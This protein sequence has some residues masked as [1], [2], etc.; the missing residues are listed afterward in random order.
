M[1]DPALEHTGAPWFL[2]NE[3]HI[4]Q[5]G[6]RGFSGSLFLLSCFVPIITSVLTLVTLHLTYLEGPGGRGD[7]PS[8]LSHPSI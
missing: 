4:C 3:V 5:A 1:A 6:I 2:V 7:F 8:L